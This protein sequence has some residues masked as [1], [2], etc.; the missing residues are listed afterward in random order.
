[1]IGVAYDFL[2]LCCKAC[3]VEMAQTQEEISAMPNADIF[4]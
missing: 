3:K 2:A 1:M 4:P